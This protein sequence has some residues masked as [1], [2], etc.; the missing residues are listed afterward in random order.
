MEFSRETPAEV[1]RVAVRLPP[2]SQMSA[3]AQFTLAGTT[4]E[5][6]K[7]YPTKGIKDVWPN[8]GKWYVDI[9][10]ELCRLYIV[11]DLVKVIKVE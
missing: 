2:R 5:K 11:P 6:A 7:F 1:S 3:E 9:N 4:E 10:H 8:Y